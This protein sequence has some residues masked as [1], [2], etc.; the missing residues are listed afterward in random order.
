MNKNNFP[1]DHALPQYF[2]LFLGFCL[3]LGILWTLLP[4]LL[5]KNAHVDILENLSWGSHFQWG[6]DKD[7]FLGAWISYGI[8]H[9]F[10]DSIWPLYLS[11]QIA[12]LLGFVAVYLL[13]RKMEIDPWM[14]LIAVGILT[15]ISYY[16]LNAVEFNDDVLS[17]PLWAFTVLF[18]Y[19]AIKSQR[20]SSWIFTGLFSGLSLMTKYYFAILLLSMFLFLIV[21][22]EA[23]KSFLIAGFYWGIA[24]FLLLCTPNILWVMGHNGIAFA[25]ALSRA[26]IGT[27][28]KTVTVADHFLHPFVFLLNEISAILP[29]FLL[30]R[31]CFT[32]NRI[33]K[34]NDFNLLY[35][36]FMLLGPIGLTILFTMATGADTY[37]SWGTPLFNQFGLFL[38]VLFQP[39]FTEMQIKRFL[40]GLLLISLTWVILFLWEETL[41]PY[42][43]HKGR[44]EHFPGRLIAADLS[45]EWQALYH[46]PLAYIAGNRL[47]AVNLSHYCYP[48]PDCFFEWNPELSPWFEESALKKQGGIFIWRILED[49]DIRLPKYI[50]RRF[51]NLS[52]QPVHIYHWLL[53]FNWLQKFFKPLPPIKVGVA[54]LPPKP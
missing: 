19:E 4:S 37:F 44:Y 28:V 23:R 43:K 54:F 41:H 33:S 15:A 47:E 49:R 1:N 20:T 18:F 39:S 13:A 9:C 10:G 29:A 16:S 46:T 50:R 31:F 45:H 34:P 21:N 32:A 25:Y 2:N 53:P 11:S 30:F 8:S 51:P 12:V 36:S 24:L 52:I 40:K 6:Y 26:G 7:P 14:S 5:L 17:I 27:C 42:F 48:H 3:G 35:L 22:Q 38:M